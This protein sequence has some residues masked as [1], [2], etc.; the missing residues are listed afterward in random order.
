[1]LKIRFESILAAC[2]AVAILGGGSASAGSLTFTLN[3]D[4][5]SGTCGTAPFG[6]V[7]ITD[8]GTGAGAFVSV[9]E[10]LAADEN[11]AGTGAGDALEFNVD[12]ASIDIT[13]ITPGA[14]LA[15]GPAPDTASTFG[16]FDFS[17]TCTVCSGGKGPTGPLSFD[18][19]SST[20]VTVADFIDNSDGNFFAADI[21]GNNGKTGN[22]GSNSLGRG[23]GGGE[24][25][26]P[27]SVLLLLSGMG[28]IGVGS[29]RRTH[30]HRN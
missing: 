7:V 11:F 18:V 29:I 3:L 10:T 23:G 15:I 22:V 26:E 1:V 13:H 9:T 27:A 28:L 5:C 8:N 25:P 21:L 12:E 4:G 17:V 20:G 2:A 6:T 24:T 19:G 14:D 16:A 30:A